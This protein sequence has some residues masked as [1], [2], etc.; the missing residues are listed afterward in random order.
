[1]LF[2]ETK[3]RTLLSKP[4]SRKNSPNHSP[5]LSPRM[6]SSTNSVSDNQKRV[7]RPDKEAF[8]LKLT[9]L[10]K[11]LK[12]KEKEV[13][14]ARN[15]V[16][17]ALGKGQ[18]KQNFNHD[19]LRAELDQIRA[20]QA[21]LKTDR[22]KVQAEI[23]TIDER[24][25]KNVKDLQNKRAKANFRSVDEI[26]AHIKQLKA[27][28]DSGNLKL[29]EERQT[30]NEISNL[31]KLRKNF[32]TFGE[33]QTE[34]DQDKAKL[35]ALRKSLNDPEVQALSDRYKEITAELDASRAQQQEAY[36]NR[37]SLF[38]KRTAAEKA[39]NDVYA[40]IKALKD[41]HYANVRAY[42]EQSKADQKARIER[43]KAERASAEKEKKLREAREKVETASEPAFSSHIATAE[44]LLKYFDTADKSAGQE[45]GAEETKTW[46]LPENAKIIQKKDEHFFA[47][48]GHKKNKA[49]GSNRK[50]DKLS[51]DLGII[52]DLSL[53]NI[54]VPASKDEIPTTVEKLK[55][56]LQFYRD[57]EDRV[58]QE[59]VERAKADLAKIEAESEPVSEASAP[60]STV[61]SE[62]VSETAS[63]TKVDA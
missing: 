45:N 47:G 17:H 3:L 55:E 28:V 11:E 57:N 16:K 44:S 52:E 54:S 29:V 49:K 41:E 27:A 12:V 60:A 8:Q 43:E 23:R 24:I 25:K 4:L 59:R 37:S 14:K 56:K 21:N 18:S 34:I 22:N 48:F 30:L 46:D 19:V 10:E 13:E 33:A 5:S 31:N 9:E 61:A 36:K 42:R 62:P 2:L 7:T 53:L 32:Y 51:M 39:R 40:Q 38:D 63:E 1:M 26:D 6:S 58:T 20:K 15:D 35:A 50:N